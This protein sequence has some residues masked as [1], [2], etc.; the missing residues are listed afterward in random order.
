MRL[1]LDTLDVA[2]R[3]LV[4]GFLIVFMLPVTFLLWVLGCLP[5]R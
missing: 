5:K 1:L 4:V 2:L 3:L